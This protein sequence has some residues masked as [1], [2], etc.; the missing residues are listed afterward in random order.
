MRDVYE[1]NPGVTSP[2]WWR[3]QGAVGSRQLQG[4]MQESL[5]PLS[6]S[7]STR[8]W[9]KSP[10]ITVAI[11]VYGAAMLGGARQD[12]EPWGTEQTHTAQQ[13][14]FQRLSELSEPDTVGRQG[15]KHHPLCPPWKLR[16]PCLHPWRGPGMA[17]VV[18]EPVLQV[19]MS[20]GSQDYQLQASI[21][22]AAVSRTLGPS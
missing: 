17:G 22:C 3:G 6:I 7:H 8:S 1:A 18:M 20:M 13:L 21:A 14:L 12:L 11:N 15:A 10:L 4:N 16:H 5:S 9:D 19:A 2:A